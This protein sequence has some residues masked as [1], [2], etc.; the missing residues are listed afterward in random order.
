MST[1]PLTERQT[2]EVLI[3]TSMRTSLHGQD[4]LRALV[5]FVIK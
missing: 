5:L 4:K 3:S 1:P 2:G